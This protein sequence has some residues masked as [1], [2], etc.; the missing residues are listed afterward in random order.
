MFKRAKLVYAIMELDGKKIK[1]YP[2]DIDAA[3]RNWF[4]I[5]GY[6]EVGSDE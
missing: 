6:E 2:K 3:G 4:F 5:T 1:V